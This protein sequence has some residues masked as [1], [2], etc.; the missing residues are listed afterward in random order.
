ME[1][2]SVINP[3]IESKKLKLSGLKCHRIHISKKNVKD[4]KCPVL[5]V[6]DKK[7]KDSMKEKY[8]RDM[9]D[10]S[11]TIRKKE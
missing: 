8:L 2:N 3:F 10:N 7:M 9:L 6:H 1:V 11:G 5:K 4:L